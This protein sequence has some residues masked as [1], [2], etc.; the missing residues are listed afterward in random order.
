MRD[1]EMY[2]FKKTEKGSQLTNHVMIVDDSVADIVGPYHLLYYLGYHVH[3]VFDGEAVLSF[4]KKQ[5]FDFIVLDLNMP[6]IGGY[7]ILKE[8]N[9]TNELKLTKIIL[10]TGDQVKSDIYESYPN[11]DI[12]DVWKKPL[13][14]SQIAARLKKFSQE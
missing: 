8:L 14:V 12:I 9:S 13:Q 10:H 11:L 6:F 4:L 7:Q 5:K 2:Q 1:T 3:T